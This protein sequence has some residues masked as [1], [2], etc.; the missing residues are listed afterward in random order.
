[1]THT[2]TRNERFFRLA[3][4]TTALIEGISWLGMLT[5]LAIKYPLHGSPLPVTIWGWVHGIAWIAFVLACI[6]AAIRFRW[7]WW[8]LPTGI[9]GSTLPFLTIPFDLWMERTGRLSTANRPTNRAQTTAP[10]PL[11]KEGS[12]KDVS[13]K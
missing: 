13:T 2:P 11:T 9:I 8:A 1:M 3:F 12:S 4:R 5:A 10:H 7:T 6:A